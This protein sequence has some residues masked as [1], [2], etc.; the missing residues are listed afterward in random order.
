MQTDDGGCFSA[1]LAVF[2]V[3]AV[4]ML[5]FTLLPVLLIGL[6]LWLFGLL[7]AAAVSG[8][9]RTRIPAD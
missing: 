7:A 8:W 2:G 9:R 5:V 6:A 3:L 4:F 1:I